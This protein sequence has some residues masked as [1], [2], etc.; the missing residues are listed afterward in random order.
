MKVRI[1]SFRPINKSKINDFYQS[2]FIDPIKSI[3]YDITLSLTQFD[4]QNVKNFIDKKKLKILHKYFKTKS[5][6]IKNT[7]IK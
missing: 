2:L 7:L 1:V 4:E 5:S 6:K 3:D